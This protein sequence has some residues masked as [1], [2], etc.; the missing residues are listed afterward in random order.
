[1]HVQS[2]CFANVN[3][4]PYYQIYAATRPFFFFFFFFFLA[5]RQLIIFVS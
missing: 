4:A 3:L 2:C 1:M 5:L